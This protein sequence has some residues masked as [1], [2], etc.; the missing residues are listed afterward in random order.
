MVMS[1][2]KNRTC[3]PPA[4]TEEEP[5][6]KAELV[7]V[8]PAEENDE[9]VKTDPNRNVP[10]WVD[11]NVHDPIEEAEYL[12]TTGEEDDSVWSKQFEEPPE[13]QLRND[14]ASGSGSISCEQSDENSR[15]VPVIVTKLSYPASSDGEIWC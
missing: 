6:V 3:N 7:G 14:F 12:T 5:D 15:D 4:V 13:S 8:L 1:P 9:E 10:Q 2:R 11:V